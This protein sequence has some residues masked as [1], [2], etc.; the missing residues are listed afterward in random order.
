VEALDQVVR[1]LAVMMGEHPAV[2]RVIV[3]RVW[4]AQVRLSIEHKDDSVRCD[5]VAFLLY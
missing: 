2:A 3:E 1:L 5:F 4:I